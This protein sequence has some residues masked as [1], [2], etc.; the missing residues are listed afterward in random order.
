MLEL[1]NSSEESNLEKPT[2]Q[3][4]AAI[5]S[6]IEII[7]DELSPTYGFEMAEAFGIK[8]VPFFLV[9]MNVGAAHS[10]SLYLIKSTNFTSRSI[11]C[12]KL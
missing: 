8:T 6:R 11:S 2:S 9:I 7:N 1:N 12:F 3:S 5:I 10:D 4:M